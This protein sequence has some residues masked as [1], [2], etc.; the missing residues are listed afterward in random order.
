[1][2]NGVMYWL[3]LFAVFTNINPPAPVARFALLPRKLAEF[4]WHQR[5]AGPFARLAYLSVNVVRCICHTATHPVLL[6]P[7]FLR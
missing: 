7:V 4:I 1:M 5:N 3:C 6:L 2:S